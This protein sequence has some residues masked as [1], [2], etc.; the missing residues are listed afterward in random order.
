MNCN[1]W[2]LTSE[3]YATYTRA[4]RENQA[5]L[6]FQWKSDVCCKDLMLQET[7]KWKLNVSVWFHSIIWTV[8]ARSKQLLRWR[9]GALAWHPNGDSVGWLSC[10]FCKHTIR[11]HIQGWRPTE[12]A[13]AQTATKGLLHKSVNLLRP[14]WYNVLW[15]VKYKNSFGLYI[16]T[17]HGW[18]FYVIKMHRLCQQSASKPILVHNFAN[19]YFF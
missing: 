15:T 3:T 5:T 9:N 16:T 7:C 13:V 18:F 6:H 14:Q 2:P 17:V 12:T 11:A 8:N 4:V 1:V 19:F 10:S